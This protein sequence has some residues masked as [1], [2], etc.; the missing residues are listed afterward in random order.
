MICCDWRILLEH[1]LIH[2]CFQ[3]HKWVNVENMMKA[4]FVGPLVDGSVN[5]SSINTVVATTSNGS[6]DS[7]NTNSTGGKTLPRMSTLGV[8]T[9]IM[10]VDGEECNII[11]V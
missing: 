6:G 8:P 4:C 11:H 5:G 9:P 7:S 10:V 3:V 1:V 2:T